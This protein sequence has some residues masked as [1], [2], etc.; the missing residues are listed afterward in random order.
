[1]IKSFF[2]SLE[3]NRV[4][5]L[6][7]SGQATVLYGAA[8]FSEDI[9]LWID[10]N[11]ENV[12]RVKK[13][14]HELKAAYYKL[15]P[16][17]DVKHLQRGHG[18]HFTLPDMPEIY[19]DIMGKPPRVGAFKDAAKKKKVM[20]TEWGAI[21]TVG[22]HDLV[23]LKLTQRL[24]DYPIIGRLVINYLSTTESPSESDFRWAIEHVFTIEDFGELARLHPRV[25]NHLQI[26]T[27]AWSYASGM[28][29]PSPETTDLLET[30]LLAKMQAARQRDRHYWR[31]IIDELKML[32]SSGQL[33]TPG[34][35]V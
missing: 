31:E 22:V 8:A 2:Q 13:T 35:L 11:E 29:N 18:L 6:L 34:E 9:D 10:P 16:R 4:D 21:P 12:G 27:P 20:A 7:I 26:H 1:M 33:A 23:A 15:S 32:R 5:Y 30:D 24:G 19:L 17:L 28:D 25:K 14:L 3:S